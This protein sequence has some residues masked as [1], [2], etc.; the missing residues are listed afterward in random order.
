M[1]RKVNSKQTFT[2]IVAQVKCW[3]L[4]QVYPV[5][6]VLLLILLGTE[7]SSRFKIEGKFPYENSGK[8]QLSVVSPHD[9]VYALCSL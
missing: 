6:Y 3:T 9:T 4:Y 1:C 2:S 5:P 8:K 7:R